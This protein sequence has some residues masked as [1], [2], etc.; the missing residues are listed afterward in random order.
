MA[1]A[2][3]S[4]IRRRRTAQPAKPNDQHVRRL[5]L[6]LTVEVETPQYDLAVVAQRLCIG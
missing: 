2:S 1:Y 6:F 5:Q 4:Q 3:G